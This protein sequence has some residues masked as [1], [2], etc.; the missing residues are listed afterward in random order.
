MAEFEKSFEQEISKLS[1]QK[2]KA[3]SKKISEA[4]RTRFHEGNHESRCEVVERSFNDE[5]LK[6]LLSVVRN[7]EHK[8]AFIL[9]AS[10]GLRVGELYNLKG[11]DL[12]GNELRITS[13]K[14]SYNSVVRLPENLLSVIPAREPE[15]RL[16]HPSIKDLRHAFSE[17]RK[18][19]GLEAVYMTTLPCGPVG[20]MNKRY[21]RTLHSLRHY[22]ISKVYASS[23]DADLT[24]RFARHRDMKATLRYLTASRKK[25]VEGLIDGLARDMP[26]EGLGERIVKAGSEI[27]VSGETESDNMNVAKELKAKELKALSIYN[28]CEREL[29]EPENYWRGLVLEWLENPKYAEQRKVCGIVAYAMSNHADLVD[30]DFPTISLPT[31]KGVH[32]VDVY[33]RIIE[34]NLKPISGDNGASAK[35]GNNGR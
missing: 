5:E 27:W 25:E 15:E 3:L 1:H 4:R 19:A 21:T 18:L 30:E 23:K 32:I 31:E 29:Q 7:P 24:R 6:R 26:T 33:W 16:F 9:M 17:Y 35:E 22:A 28:M 2:L 34:A 14:G 12:N 11:R 13:S 10:L 8:A 20:S